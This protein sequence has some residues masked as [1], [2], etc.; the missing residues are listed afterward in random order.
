MIETSLDKH[1]QPPNPDMRPPIPMI[2]FD[3]H[4]P[5]PLAAAFLPYQQ[6]QPHDLHYYSP[7]NHEV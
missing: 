1:Q 5:S 4:Q 6:K 2:Y 7:T 3:P